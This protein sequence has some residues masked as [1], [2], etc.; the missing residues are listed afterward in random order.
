MSDVSDLL[1]AIGTLVSTLAG[2]FVMVWTSVVQPR[3]EQR[4][5]A[6][7]AASATAARILEALADGELSPEELEEI[8]GSLEQEES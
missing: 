2:A 3:R 4:A 7:R 1:V 6:Q 5:A 8:R